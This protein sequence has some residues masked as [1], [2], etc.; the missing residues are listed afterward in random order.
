MFI[1]I[2]SDEVPGRPSYLVKHTKF[3]DAIIDDPDF[4]DNNIKHNSKS[5]GKSKKKS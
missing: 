5:L 1:G 3:E 2:V 4:I